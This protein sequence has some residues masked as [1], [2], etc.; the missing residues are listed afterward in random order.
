MQQ[1]RDLIVNG[2]VGCDLIFY[3]QPSWPFVKDGVR[4]D[5]ESCRDKIDDMIHAYLILND[6]AYIEIAAPDL[7]TRVSTV[8]THVERHLK[9]RE[10]TCGQSI[11]DQ[12]SEGHRAME[13]RVDEFVRP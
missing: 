1:I 10:A 6:I 2:G 12:M 3:V 4:D 11:A 8:M 7:D 5:H 13:I 9:T